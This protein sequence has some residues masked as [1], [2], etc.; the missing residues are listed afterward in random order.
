M[1]PKFYLPTNYTSREVEF[2]LSR[3]TPRGWRFYGRDKN[4]YCIRALNAK[5]E[6]LCNGEKFATKQDAAIMARALDLP[7]YAIWNSRTRSYD[8]E[9]AKFLVHAR[10]HAE[11]V[12]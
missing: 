9:G 3:D 5:G 2:V 11:N 8:G 4:G 10:N 1:T 6:P 7:A 12:A